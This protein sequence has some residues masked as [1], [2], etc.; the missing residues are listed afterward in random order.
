VLAAV[1][2]VAVSGCAVGADPQFYAEPALRADAREAALA[3]DFPAD[4]DDRVRIDT[5]AVAG[6]LGGPGRLRGGVY[7]VGVPG[8]GEAV[9]HPAGEGRAALTGDVVVPASTVA[10]AV[11]ALEGHG[12]TV[13]A[14]EHRTGGEP[15]RAALHVW[16]VND[17]GTIARGLRAALDAAP[18]Q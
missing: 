5:A 4:P 18:G 3:A 12:I 9:F 15:A 17:A 13:T 11:R 6:A 2:A 8:G 16:A 7:A 14:V 1:A 10:V